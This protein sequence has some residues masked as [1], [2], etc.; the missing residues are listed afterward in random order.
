MITEEAVMKKIFRNQKMSAMITLSTA[1]VTGVCTL[2]LFLIANSNMV[3]AIRDTTMNHMETSLDAKTQ[4]IEQSIGHAESLLISYGKTPTV[5]ELLKDPDNPEKMQKAQTFTEQLFADLDGWEGIYISDWETHVLAHSNR[6]AI[7]MIMREGDRLK[8]LQDAITAADGIYNTGIFLSPASGQ[9]VISLYYPVYDS[10]GTT[11]IGFVGGAKTAASIQT[12][13]D[14]I[15][16]EGME[17]AIDYMINVADRTHIFDENADLMA[18]QIE[19]P[20]MLS[21]IDQINQAPDVRMGNLE[22]TD[23]AGQPCIAVYHYMPERQW[24]VV[25]SDTKQEIFARANANR[26]VLGILCIASFLL[27]SFLSFM[28]VRINMKPLKIVEESLV[29]LQNLELTE[30]KTIRK[31]IGRTSETGRIATAT[32]LLYSTFQEIVGTL[33]ECTNSLNSST[34][35]TNEA[36]RILI[37]FVGDNC[38]TT[39]ELAAGIS[40]TNSAIEGVAEEIGTLSELVDSVESKVNDGNEKSEELLHTAQEMKAMAENTLSETENRIEE[41][42]RNA[43]SA[44]TSL[45]AL[46]RINDMV[47]QILDIAGQTNLLS[48]NASIEAARAGEQGR[49]FAVVAQEIGNLAANSSETAE[50]IQEICAEINTNIDNV[51]ACFDDIIQFMEQ[52]VSDKFR[53]FVAIANEYD[54]S[55]EQIRQAIYEIDESSNGFLSSIESIQDQMNVIRATSADNE[56]GVDDIVRVIEQTNTTTE[57]LKTV[58]IAN[59]NNVEAINRLVKKFK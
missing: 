15:E 46:T 34:G 57:E 14:S 58:V 7:G 29:R 47:A 54:N 56:S 4:T 3:S 1:V 9:L 36:T 28:I 6:D 45:Q 33:D 27:I 8:Q 55:V 48:L 19:N 39:E 12:A 17:H 37:D 40:T 41:N 13:F 38:A 16:A 18:T 23:D 25:L 35:K 49:G 26:L 44:M 51:R 52:D 53:E 11:M 21:I 59:E 32:D 22:Y 2:F 24:A 31:Y 5:A 20:M 43:E 30:P 10:D 42:R 50:H